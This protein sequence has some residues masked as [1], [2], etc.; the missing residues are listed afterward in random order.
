MLINLRQ[1]FLFRN[2]AFQYV[3]FSY[4]SYTWYFMVHV[5]LQENSRNFDVVNPVLLRSGYV[6]M[7][8]GCTS[9]GGNIAARPN[10]MGNIHTTGTTNSKGDPTPSIMQTQTDLDKQEQEMLKQHE[11]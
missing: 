3:R 2:D 8:G 11:Q 9:R 6:P 7:T 4:V 10:P 1:I 5:T